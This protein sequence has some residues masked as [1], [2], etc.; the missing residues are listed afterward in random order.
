MTRRLL[1]CLVTCIYAVVLTNRRRRTRDEFCENRGGERKRV[2]RAKFAEERVNRAL[3][4]FRFRRPPPP[5]RPSGKVG[6]FVSPTCCP[7]P[8]QW[9]RQCDNPAFNEIRTVDMCVPSWKSGCTS[10]LRA[11]NNTDTIV[12]SFSRIEFSLFVKETSKRELFKLLDGD[13]SS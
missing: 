11:R 6:N 10:I 4:L 8:C 5:P 3:A 12:P 2:G 1:P 13:I 7:P 9:T